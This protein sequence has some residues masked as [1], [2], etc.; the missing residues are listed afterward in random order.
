[1]ITPASGGSLIISNY[2]HLGWGSVMVCPGRL[3]CFLE[4]ISILYHKDVNPSVLSF[5]ETKAI[6]K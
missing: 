1:M 6:E 3:C 2:L 5:L 4:A